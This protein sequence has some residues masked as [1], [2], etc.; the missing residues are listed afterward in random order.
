MSGL[1]STFDADRHTRG[2]PDRRGDGLLRYHQSEQERLVLTWGWQAG[3]AQPW[4]PLSCT[5]G[6][7]QS[8]FNRLHRVIAIFATTPMNGQPPVL[9]EDGEQTR[10]LCYV[11]TSPATTCCRQERTRRRPAGQRR[12]G[13]RRPSVRWRTWYP[14]A[15]EVPMSRGDRRVSAGEMSHRPGHLA[16]RPG[17]LCSEVELQD[18]IE[19]YIG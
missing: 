7:R 2:G 3:V 17:R 5:Y 1:W 16:C 12:S 15:L 11:G 10:D 6:P 19:S 18:G 14:E 4:R 8:I 9:Y 13:G